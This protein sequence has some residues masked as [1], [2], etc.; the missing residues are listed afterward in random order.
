MT[1]SPSESIPSSLRPIWERMPAGDRVR[2]MQAPETLRAQLV[3]L[4]ASA[5]TNSR[6]DDEEPKPFADARQDDLDERLLKRVKAG[7][8]GPEARAALD[9]C[10]SQT[11]HG[12][13]RRVFLRAARKAIEATRQ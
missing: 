11:G 12:T 13:T 3:E 5:Q 4:W 9:E 8:Y 2:V 1:G 7:E 6:T 10:E